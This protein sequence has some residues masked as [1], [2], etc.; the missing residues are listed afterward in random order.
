VK[1]GPWLYLTTDEKR[2]VV[3]VRGPGDRE[4]IDALGLEARYSRVGHGWVVDLEHVADVVAYA[5]SRHEL[6]VVSNRCPPE[7]EAS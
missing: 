6:V 3:L 4:V 5:E 2:G 7:R 1:R